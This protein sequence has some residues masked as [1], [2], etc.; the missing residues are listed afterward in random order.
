M[1]KTGIYPSLS[2]VPDCPWREGYD[3]MNEGSQIRLPSDRTYS[4]TLYWRGITQPA[5]LDATHNPA[6]LP[7][8]SRVMISHIAAMNYGRAAAKNPA[9]VDEMKDYLGEPWGNSKGAFA[10][11]ALTWRTAFRNGGALGSVTGR[12]L[13]LTNQI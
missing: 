10:R 6:L 13:A 11:W 8:A 5:D 2:S 9:L 3:Y 12:M 1:G 4:G 7:E